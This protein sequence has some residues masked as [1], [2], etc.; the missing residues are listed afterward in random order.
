MSIR[1]SYLVL[2]NKLLVNFKKEK[3]LFF[4]LIFS[5]FL[6]FV[7]F[8]NS[9]F[10][11][12]IIA[13][14]DWSFPQDKS[15]LIQ[16]WF[17]SW[18]PLVSNSNVELLSRLSLFSPIIVLFPRE[19]L[20]RIIL[21]LMF[22]LPSFAM[23]ITMFKFLEPLCKK[24]RSVILGSLVASIVYTLNPFYLYGGRMDF[25]LTYASLPALL[26]L[27]VKIFREK[28]FGKAVQ[29]AIIL[30]LVVSILLFPN[31]IHGIAHGLALIAYVAII[32][33]VLNIRK[34]FRKY[35]SRTILLIVATTVIPLF[36]N[37]Y[38][39]LPYFA[40][41]ISS[42]YG[43]QIAHGRPPNLQHLWLFSLSPFNALT[44]SFP[45]QSPETGFIFVDSRLFPIWI[46]SYTIIAL[47][48]YLS[49]LVIMFK[50]NDFFIKLGRDI[51][52]LLSSLIVVSS[53]SSFIWR[54][55][56]T[57]LNS[58]YLWMLNNIPYMW[59]LFKYPYV[60]TFY[61]SLG[62]AL[63]LGFFFAHIF[64]KID[65]LKKARINKNI[66]IY[67][68]RRALTTLDAKVIVTIFLICLPVLFVAHPLLISGNYMGIFNPSSLPEEYILTNKFLNSD[69]EAFRTLWLPDYGQL[70]S[71]P[72]GHPA[73]WY[74]STVPLF[75]DRT[76]VGTDA[77]DSFSSVRR[78][79]NI[80]KPEE[81]LLKILGFM[82]V[83]YIIYQAN[84]TL[85]NP[86]ILNNLL[87]QNDL[88][89]VFQKNSI[90]IF[91]NKLFQPFIRSLNQNVT[92]N[93]VKVNPT[94]WIV[95]VKAEN[96]FILIF[97][98]PYDRNWEAFIGNKKLTNI[99]IGSPSITITDCKS[100][101]YF[102]ASAAEGESSM[103]LSADSRN[104]DCSLKASF[105]PAKGWLWI[106]YDPPELI[107]LS[108]YDVLKFW[109]K[110]DNLVAGYSFVI[111]FFDTKGNFGRWYFDVNKASQ[112]YEVEVPLHKLQNYVDLSKIDRI[113]ISYNRPVK[114]GLTVM[115]GNFTAESVI[116]LLNAFLVNETGQ[117]SVIIEYRPQ[118]YMET[119]AYVSIATLLLLSIVYFKLSISTRRKLR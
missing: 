42:A 38:A 17:Y 20:E 59:G 2:M 90:W 1:S 54:I 93:Y 113:Q 100:I 3:Y 67:K 116:P 108:N 55:S 30:S 9:L 4:G 104:E 47:L 99:K 65:S 12:G 80:D 13:A 98:E 45:A 11:S 56:F 110:V 28:T 57:P 95:N 53:L 58:L 76:A 72:Y 102:N 10:S 115:L 51:I 35:L 66:T 34:N 48:A 97:A 24:Q 109:I 117:F 107:D 61:T 25:Y 74:T 14:Y 36:V 106:T 89:L 62:F 119:G 60:F 94:K 27:V 75:M 69:H 39:V 29:E 31:A 22:F 40:S 111:D 37:A 71:L 101:S 50:K 21:F 41:G 79:F 81:K 23:W 82:S 64:D 52:I 112:W 70:K 73:S 5:I 78:I 68:N 83:K 32:K 18:N 118:A 85:S 26:Y 7:I 105:T 91:K 88:E 86:E 8:R 43:P 96:P 92:L 46:I 103:S 49:M 84:T 15:T 19:F 77:Y 6:S 63:L 16:A 114:M 33:L 44:A 87:N